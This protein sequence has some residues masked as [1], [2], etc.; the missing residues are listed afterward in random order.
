MIDATAL[1]EKPALT[2]D[3][4]RLVPL[5]VRHAAA[6]HAACLTRRPVG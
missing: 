6:F 1:S 5:S 4:V 2:G 3:R